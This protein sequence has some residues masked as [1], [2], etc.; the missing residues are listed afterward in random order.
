MHESILSKRYT[1]KAIPTAD[2]RPSELSAI[3]KPHPLS[4]MELPFDPEYSLYCNRMTPERLNHVTDDEQ[5]WAVRQKVILRNTGEF[6][7][8]ISGPDAETFV[9]RVFARDVSRVKVGRCSY[10]FVLYHH[11]G[12]ITDGVMLRLA[13]DRFW[14][15]QADG[16]LSNWYMAHAH[17]F[18]VTISDPNV[19]VSQVQGPR[20][21]D[22]LRDVIDGEFPD[23]WRYFD[24]ATVRIA[25][26]EVIITRTGFTNELGWEFYLRPENDAEKVGNRI[27]EV[28]QRHGMILT[29]TPVFRARRIEAGLMSQAEFDSTTTPFDAGLGHFVQMDKP[30]FIGKAALEKADKRSRTFGLRVRGGIAERGRTIS[31]GAKTVG[32]V[33]SSTWSPYQECGVALVRMDDPEMGPGT[34]V[35]VTGTDGATY[36]AQLCS[37]PMYDAEGAIVRG[38]NTMIPEGPEP[39]RG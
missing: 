37:L 26:E 28:G 33:C 30:D 4:Y 23:P 27:L 9:N 10:N 12:M 39:W 2:R 20:S 5:Y 34:E 15:A 35:E 22:V 6:P 36:S 1:I 3:M 38:R 8:E 14:M 31:V 24:I 19:W 16:E 21:M 7:V 29:G 17:E 11:G 18:D 32:R 13:E 25:G